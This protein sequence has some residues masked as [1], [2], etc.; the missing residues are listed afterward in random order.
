MDGGRIMQHGTHA[1]LVALK[2]PLR[3]VVERVERSQLKSR[4]S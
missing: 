1:E 3:P 4:V 2:R